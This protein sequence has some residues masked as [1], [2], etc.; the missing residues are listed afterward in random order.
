MLQIITLRNLERYLKKIG[1]LKDIS[2]ENNV[3]V[4]ERE[5]ERERENE[6]IVVNEDR[7]AGRQRKGK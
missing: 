5:R 1:Q 6:I 7:Q 3:C 2:N 4:C